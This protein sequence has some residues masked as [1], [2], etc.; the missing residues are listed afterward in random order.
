MPLPGI[1]QF[2][3][4]RDQAI[5]IRQSHRLSLNA[6]SML[7]LTLLGQLSISEVL[8]FDHCSLALQV[9]R[10]RAAYFLCKPVKTRRDSFA[11]ES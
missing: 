9:Y 4:A 7:A 2:S 1:S 11:S 5:D 3:L 6:C 10:T 8:Q